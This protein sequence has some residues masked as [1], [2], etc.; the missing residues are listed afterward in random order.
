MDTFQEVIDWIEASLTILYC[1]AIVGHFLSL[2]KGRLNFEEF[3]ST[4]RIEISGN[5]ETEKEEPAKKIDE[6][7]QTYGKGKPVKIITSKNES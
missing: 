5:E 4:I 3:S 7:S 2:P 6:F 1:L